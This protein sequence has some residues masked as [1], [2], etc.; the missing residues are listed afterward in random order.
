VLLAIGSSLLWTAYERNADDGVPETATVDGGTILL[1][2]SIFS[3][4]DDF[5]PTLWYAAGTSL[6]FAAA[7]SLA[8]A[9]RLR[10]RA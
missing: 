4:G 9:A 10:V 2:P 6:V 8:V 3:S 7:V 5:D 1:G